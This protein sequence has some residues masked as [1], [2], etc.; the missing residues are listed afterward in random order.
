M[1][2]RAAAVLGA[3]FFGGYATACGATHA[4][5]ARKPRRDKADARTFTTT[6]SGLTAVCVRRHNSGKC[7]V[8]LPPP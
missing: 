1:R 4:D 3:V 6:T 2:L 7:S 8:E 5:D